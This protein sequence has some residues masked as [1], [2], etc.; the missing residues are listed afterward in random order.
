M[1]AT[2][3]GRIVAPINGLSID[4]RSLSPGDLF[5]A[6]KGEN[7]DGHDF[8]GQAME[9]GAMAVVSMA[10][11]FDFPQTH[12]LLIVEEPLEALR[13]LGRAAR[14]RSK[15]RLV[16]VTG[17]VG[18]TGTKEALRQIFSEQG[19]TH[20]AVS[21]YN[22][23]WGVPLT[24]ARMPADTEF[25]IAE[26]GMNSPGEIR[27]LTAMARPHAAIVTTIEPVHLEF[28]P[29][30][31]AI[32][33][34]KAE[35]F[36]GVEPGGTAIV[37]I[38]NAQG[39]RLVA[40]AQ[41]SRVGRVVTIGTES[42][43]DFRL[44]SVLEDER[45][46]D[47]VIEAFARRLSCR[48]G[49]P[50]RHIVM[51]MLA[52]LAAVHA[53]GADIEKAAAALARLAPPQ[54]RG[55]RIALQLQD[56][57]ATLIDESYNANPASMR[58]MLANLARLAPGAGGRRVVVLGDMLELGREGPRFHEELAA[59]VESSRVDLVH[60]SGPLMRHLFEALPESRRGYYAASSAELES[61]VVEAVRGGDVIAVKGSLGSRM[62]RIVQAL[63]ARHGAV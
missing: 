30:V 28:F 13:R 54:G 22:N 20:A 61:A 31:A 56:G 29:S 25:A 7:R 32:A 58:A 55:A 19:R 16:A 4:T 45:G 43:A 38:D 3:R 34:A 48:I 21:S 44:V 51:N 49:M 39:A 42:E 36:E 59:A 18:K 60:A 10:R 40:H 62:G 35:I 2:V 6:I 47:A 5:F 17:S 52:V 24:L 8:V 33:D 46:S 57:A 1:G 27:P 12:R 63:R 23:H 26:I 15:A 11:A 50:G 53:L 37:N 41:A 14:A 9:K